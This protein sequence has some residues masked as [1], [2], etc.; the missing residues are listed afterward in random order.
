VSDATGNVHIEVTFRANA[1][2]DLALYGL[3]AGHV[4][5]EGIDN[6][7]PELL[8]NMTSFTP[9]ANFFPEVEGVV[10]VTISGNEVAGV[11]IQIALKSCNRCGRYLPVN[12]PPNERV[13]LSYSNHCIARA[14]CNHAS[15]G[16][17]QD[18]ERP[19]I[20]HQMHFG[21]QLECRYCKKFFVNAA[22]N[23]Q[24]TAGQMKEDGARRRAF[25]VLLEHLHR[26]SPQFEYKKTTGRDLATDVFDRFGGS[27]FKCGKKFSS[28][29]EMHLDHTRPLALL[30]PL[31]EHATALCSTHN[32][33][34]RD[35]APKDF[36]TSSELRRLAKIT[37]LSYSDLV[38]PAPNLAAIRLLG[39][40][41]DWFFDEFIPSGAL[42]RVREGKATAALLVKALQKAI[43]QVPGGAPFDL[44]AEAERRGIR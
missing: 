6:A 35:R 5:D 1:S 20:V 23:P 13:T 21:F 24:R 16:R 8:R 28:Q 33:E 19:E 11:P 2:C 3:S 39:K 36:Y 9:E 26:G 30:W 4:K 18:D 38:N 10:T 44:V 7:R 42:D 22:L 27:C 40:N 32:S 12:M 14:P 31:D 41:I 25:E 34:K 43:N 37:G 15:F 17:I 29:R